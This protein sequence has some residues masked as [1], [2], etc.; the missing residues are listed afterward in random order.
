MTIHL[1]PPVP[2]VPPHDVEVKRLNGTAMSVSFKNL[3]LVEARSLNVIYYISYSPRSSRKRQAPHNVRVP[4]GKNSVVITNLDPKLD[5]DVSM[6]ATNSEGDS[7]SSPT[8]A[9]TVPTGM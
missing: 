1:I 3:S 5:Y 7:N 9:A 8:K 2:A 6:Y 4:D